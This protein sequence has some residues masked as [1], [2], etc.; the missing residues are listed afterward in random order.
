[1]GLAVVE[2]LAAKGWKIAIFDFD[3]ESGEKVAQRLGQKVLFIKGNVTKYEE[4]GAAFAETWKKWE[5]IHFGKAQVQ[6]LISGPTS[7]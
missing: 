6:F 1:M 5:S 3:R 4:L 2:D 7:F